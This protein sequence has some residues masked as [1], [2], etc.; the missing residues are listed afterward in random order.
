[1]SSTIQRAPRNVPTAKRDR[2]RGHILDVIKNAA[3]GSSLASERDLADTLGVSRPTV[4]AAIEELTREGLLVR[5]QGR[6]TFTSPHV[7]T[8]ELAGATSSALAVPPAEGT[9]TSRVV[10]FKT[11]PAGSSRATRFG[12]SAEASLRRVTRVRIVEDEPI[13][14]ETLELPALLVPRL[15]AADLESGNFYQLLRQRYGII[16]A[17]ALQTMEPTVANPEQAELLE[18]PVYAPLLRIE[19]TTRDTEGR[20]VEHAQSVYR[21]DRYRITSKL[22]FDQ[23]SG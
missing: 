9:W 3:P 10:A 12:I 19:R 8:Q 14:I 16:V 5:H 20:V 4:R 21:G 18:V 11:L 2:V 22:R 1:M 23:T 7:I 17:E 13:A 6:G 15:A